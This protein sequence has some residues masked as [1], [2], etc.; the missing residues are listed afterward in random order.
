[1]SLSKNQHFKFWEAVEVQL[2]S[3]AFTCCG[4]RV[5]GPDRTTV[6]QVLVFWC[7]VMQD[8]CGQSRL[9]SDRYLKDWLFQLASVPLDQIVDALKFWA[10]FWRDVNHD[11]GPIL[12]FATFKRLHLESVGTV[13][14]FVRQPLSDIEELFLRDYNPALLHRLLTCLE[15]PV[16]MTI[17]KLPS[18][19]SLEEEKYLKLE[20]EMVG[21][22]YDVD[23]LE[24]LRRIIR[25][26]FITFPDIDFWPRHGNG[27]V[28]DVR[29]KDST[30][31]YNVLLERG[32]PPRLHHLFCQRGVTH[33]LVNMNAVD[34]STSCR[35]LFVPK[36]VNSKRVISAEPTAN[37][38]AQQAVRRA[39]AD[40]LPGSLFKITQDDQG[41]NQELAQRGSFHRDFAT[42]D[43]SSASDT[44]TW[45]LID[46]IFR[47]TSIYPWLWSTR[48]FRATV[49]DRMVPLQK[50]APMGSALCFPIMSIVF[51][52]IVLLASEHVGVHQRFVVYGDDIIC[53]RSVYDEVLRL[54]R[55]LHFSVNE[56]KT[57]SPESPFKESC[58]KEYYYGVDVTPFRIPRFFQGWKEGES[59]K[60][61]PAR[62]VGWIS[63]A[64][65][66]FEAGLVLPRTYLVH[67]LLQ[68]C[69]HVAFAE[70]DRMLAIRSIRPSN[71]H[72]RSEYETVRPR[73]R[74]TMKNYSRGSLVRAVV[75]RTKTKP[76]ADDIRYQMLLEAYLHTPR[77]SLVMPEDLI[78]LKAGPSQLLVREDWIPVQFL[79][80]SSPLPSPRM[81][82]EYSFPEEVLTHA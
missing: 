54:L 75:V 26:G 66:M 11:M 53:H 28:S 43:L 19:E 44:I 12:S 77:T 4:D 48:S 67:R 33:P 27:A 23:T 74:K 80:D 58:G 36:G 51:A 16:R 22:E 18:L 31:K 73:A 52:A 78:D 38:W 14:R 45:R 65:R 47:D 9:R 71:F 40:W 72:L 68:L 49:G 56:K 63:L 32:L 25:A 64:N 79:T 21:W 13:F 1:M 17:S 61:S 5:V 69:P 29:G 37:Q 81:L 7:L 30:T 3:K 39:L 6:S 70:H 60:E 50:Y 41:R 34:K 24:A 46:H 76:G 57:F 59:V 62:L 8:L 2:R 42:I 82:C 55:A 35:V 20:E 10:G 15:F